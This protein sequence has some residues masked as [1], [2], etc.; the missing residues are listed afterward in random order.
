[1]Y[2][3]IISYQIILKRKN[4]YFR[5]VSQDTRIYTPGG[6]LVILLRTPSLP[7]LPHLTPHRSLG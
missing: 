3:H 7:L 2:N 5:K 4:I 6:S 1:M